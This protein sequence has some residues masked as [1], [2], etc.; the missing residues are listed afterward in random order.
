[1]RVTA[2]YA[3]SDLRI[4]NVEQAEHDAFLA[5]ARARGKTA[6]MLVATVVLTY[7]TS[8]RRQDIL[9]LRLSENPRGWHPRDAAQIGR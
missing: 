2:S 1:M 8:Q 7:L 3:C 9:A 6:R 5:F 4:R